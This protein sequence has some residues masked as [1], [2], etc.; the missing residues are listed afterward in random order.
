MFYSVFGRTLIFDSKDH[1]LEYR[2]F[3]RKNM[4]GVGAILTKD[5]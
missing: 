2:N 1:A 3:C 4:Q 5:G